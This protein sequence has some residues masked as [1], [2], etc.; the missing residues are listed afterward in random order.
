ML[1]SK[2]EENVENNRVALRQSS[3]ALKPQF[4][5]DY[6][7]ARKGVDYSDPMGAY[8]SPFRKVKKMFKHAA[9]EVL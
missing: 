2:P 8:S 1:F 4:V 9:F 6:K 3:E 5:L 7:A